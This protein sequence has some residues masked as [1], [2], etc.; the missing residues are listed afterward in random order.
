MELKGFRKL[1]LAPGTATT[2]EFALPVRDLAMLDAD[3]R[4]VVEPGAFRIMV[5]RSSRD[6]RLHGTVNVTDG[7]GRA[8]A[9][10]PGTGAET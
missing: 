10:P 4:R 9:A 7:G 5:G 6:I 3:M 1:R 8:T 2:V